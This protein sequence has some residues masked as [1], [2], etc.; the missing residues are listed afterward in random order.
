MGGGGGEILLMQQ[1][2]KTLIEYYR[3]ALNI[4]FDLDLEAAHLYAE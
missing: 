1:P 4:M 2:L 3:Q